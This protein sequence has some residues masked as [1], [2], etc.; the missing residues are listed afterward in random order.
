MSRQF[1]TNEL[2]QIIRQYRP[3][4]GFTIK[5][6]LGP[7]YPEWEDIVQDVLTQVI[8]KLQKGE[9]REECSLGTFI[10]TITKRRIIDCIRQKAKAS[11]EKIEE[12]A[13]LGGPE[14]DFLK[15][16]RAEIISQTLFKLKPKFREILYLYYYK[17]L[18][19]EEVA[20]RLGLSVRQVSERLYY[21]QKILARSLRKFFPEKN[22]NFALLRRLK[23]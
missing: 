18:S 6:A 10:Y 11:S 1:S 23:K 8:S 14:E 2:E 16:E 13:S 17:E 12:I 20:A 22:S 9:F 21:A 3:I 7:Q 15:K 4:I 5:K 19:R